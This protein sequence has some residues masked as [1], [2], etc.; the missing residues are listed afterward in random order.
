MAKKH[1]SRKCLC[2]LIALGIVSI[3]G[4][5]VQGAKEKKDEDAKKK[6]YALTEAQLQSHLMSFADRFTSILDTAIAQFEDLDPTGKSRYE[7]LELMTFSLHHAF[8]I[9]AESDPKVA[10]LDMFSMVTLGR[11]F[12]EEEGQSRYGKLVVP[13]INGYRRAEA[14]ISNV[15]S[16]VIAPNQMLNLMKIIKEWRKDNPEVKSF[17]LI[18]FSNFAADRRQSTLTRIKE[19]EG[20]FDSVESA[21]E[22]AEEMRLLGERSAYLATRMPQLFG[23]FGDL[24]LTRWMSNPDVHKVLADFSKLSEVTSRLAATAESL[25]DQ[26]TKERKQTIKQAM[27]SISKERS[28]TITQFVSELSAERKAAI[29]DFLA[30]EQ[31]IKGLLSDLRQTLETGNEL[32]VSA[33]TF[34]TYQAK[35]FDIGDYQKTLVELS[36]SAQQLT[37][38]ATSIERISSN[39]DVV[40]LIPQVVKAINQAESKGEALSSHTMRLILVIIGVW[41]V[42]YV[43]AKLLI[44]YASNKISVTAR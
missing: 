22:T 17:P 3:A 8:I 29:D 43:V 2:L 25:P 38:L 15:A 23:L 9:A 11:M 24:W 10:L 37:K 4:G 30:E 35:P 40:Q 39:I 13:V 12:F 21:S 16:K 14:D 42:A 36:T 6:A 18:R 20:L 31:R 28:N 1:F 33:N 27:E 32:I 19:H 7:V 5:E 34:M 41:F 26:I 44:Q